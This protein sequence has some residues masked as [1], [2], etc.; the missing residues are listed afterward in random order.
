MAV[1]EELPPWEYVCMPEA[2]TTKSFMMSSIC[3]WFA[4]GRLWYDY[5]NRLAR[6]DFNSTRANISLIYHFK[7]DL[8]WMVKDNREC[9]KW[10]LR[11]EQMDPPCLN[12]TV[13]GRARIGTATKAD[14]FIVHR[15]WGSFKIL[16]DEKYIEEPLRKERTPVSLLGWVKGE[17][18]FVHNFWDFTKEYVIDPGVFHPPIMCNLAE[19]E[20]PAQH[21]SI[22]A[23][24]SF[25]RFI[26]DM[27]MI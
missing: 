23:H 16:I 2:W 12:G 6:A 14:A 15:K 24:P 5:P 4:R 1:G 20:T 18:L 25:M 27:E 9:F 7:Q 3:D 11:G 26:S 22:F 17:G 8:V 19:E 10:N 21:H 13:K